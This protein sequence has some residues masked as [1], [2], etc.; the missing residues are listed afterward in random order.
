M[1]APASRDQRN[2]RTI[3]AGT[4]ATLGVEFMRNQSG[5]VEYTLVLRFTDGSSSTLVFTIAW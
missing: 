4:R 1:A 5:T 2:D 3:S